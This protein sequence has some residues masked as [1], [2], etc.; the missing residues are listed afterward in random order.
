MRVWT[1]IYFYVYTYAYVYV[2][3]IKMPLCIFQTSLP[4][5][6]VEIVLKKGLNYVHTCVFI[7]FSTRGQQKALNLTVI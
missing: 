2:L 1:C 4:L 7:V 3:Y 6:A 5:I